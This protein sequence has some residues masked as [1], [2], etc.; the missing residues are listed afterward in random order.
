MNQSWGGR[1]EEAWK[2]GSGCEARRPIH[3]V[4]RLDYPHAIV[5]Q[6]DYP[7]AIVGV[8]FCKHP[9]EVADECAGINHSLYLKREE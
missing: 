6:L 4:L 8:W 1:V 7:H 9:V 2:M 3:I 5:L